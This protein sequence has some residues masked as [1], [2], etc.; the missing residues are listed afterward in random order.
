MEN[1]VKGEGSKKVVGDKDVG[2]WISREE[3]NEA[4]ARMKRNK[5][6][7]KEWYGY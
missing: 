5:A 2:N 1:R 7:R 6:T 4:I 3:V